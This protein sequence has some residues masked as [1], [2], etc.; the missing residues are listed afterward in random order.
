M[1]VPASTHT[2]ES[3]VVD[4][5]VS[6]VWNLL[7]NFN[8]SWWDLVESVNFEGSGSAACVGSIATFKFKDGF[9]W[10]VQIVEFSSIKKFLTFEVIHASTP[11]PFSS[12]IHTISVTRVTSSNATFVEWVA[13]FSND[14]SAAV[15]ADSSFKRLEALADLGGVCAELGNLQRRVSDVEARS[16]GNS[17]V[18]SRSRTSSHI[19]A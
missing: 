19:S 13:D 18:E 2:R 9:S 17:I 11:L 1:S 10:T 5:P 4:S 15:M 12:A 16:R 6:I 3:T 8:F 7:S 14:A